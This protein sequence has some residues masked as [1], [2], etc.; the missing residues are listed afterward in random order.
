[1]SKESAILKK[2]G[3]SV[4]ANAVGLAVSLFVTLALPRFYG[5]DASSYGYFQVFLFYVGYVGLLHMGWCDGILL[6][7]AGKDYTELDRPLYS[8]QFWLMSAVETVLAVLTVVI[9]CYAVNDTEYS[10]IWILVGINLVVENIRNLLSYILQATGRVKEYSVVTILLNLIYVLLLLVIIVS[11]I[12]D[13]RVAV[14]AYT[15]GHVVSLGA[16]AAYCSEVIC[17]RPSSLRSAFKE[18]DDNIR[19]GINLLMA[20]LAGLLITGILRVSVQAR[21]D[22]ATYGKIAFTFSASSLLISFTQAVEV[23]L[24]PE[25]RRTEENRIRDIYVSVETGLMTVMYGALILFYP[26]RQVLEAWLPSY[27]N[28]I[29]YMAILLPMCVF[30]AKSSLLVQNY[31]KVYRLEHKIMLINL[32]SLAVAGIGTVLSVFILDN[33]VIAMLSVVLAQMVR[34]FVGEVMLSPYTKSGVCKPI[35]TDIVI[36]ILFIVANHMIGGVIGMLIY[37]AGYI[38]YVVL[39]RKEIAGLIYR[40]K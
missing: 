7:T 9:G 5:E 10:F 39:W 34:C 11:D 27:A 24:F 36:V 19:I 2:I 22:V 15:I 20:N 31:M 14:M 12:R 37:G 29:E 3:Y 4:A 18:A 33:L 8:S 23:V 40:S 17:T 16:A 6:K 1:M 21:W 35:V 38:G 28:A 25:L 26:I 32:L 13:Y 30:A